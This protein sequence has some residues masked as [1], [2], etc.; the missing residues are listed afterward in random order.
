[1][2]IDGFGIWMRSELVFDDRYEG[3]NGVLTEKVAGGR[4]D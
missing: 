2:W 3:I 1:V 4:G